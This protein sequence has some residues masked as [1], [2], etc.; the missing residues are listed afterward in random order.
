MLYTKTKLKVTPLILSLFWL[1]LLMMILIPTP[2]QAQ[3][4][5]EFIYTVQ[6]GDV[7]MLIALRYNLKVTD[8]IL[9]NNLT[10]PNLVFPG[11]QLI[12][13]GLPVPATPAPTLTPIP[14]PPPTNTGVTHQVL[15]G[16]TLFEIATFY[17]LSIDALISANDL[18][19][20]DLIQTG[21]ILQIP[22][23]PQPPPE[24]LAAPFVAVTLSEPA[25]MQGRTLVVKVTLA[26]PAAL[27]GQFETLPLFF[28][29]GPEQFWSIVPVYALAEP[30]MYPLTLTT[31]LADGLEMT[32][33]KN[34]TIVEGPYSTENI[35]LDESRET[36]LDPELVR[37]EQ[38]KMDNLWSQVS[39]QPHWA[40][41]FA[42]PIEV[43]TLR[44]TSNFGTRR[45]Y[46]NG[47]V[48]GF[49]GG[50][51]FGG[52]YGTPIYAPAAG[53]VVLAEGLTVRGNAV[54]IDH[55]LG[56]FSGY[57]HLSQLAVMPGQPVLPGE[58]VG[59]LGDTG[60]VTGPHLHWEMRLNGIAVEPL[61]WV[62][63][64]IP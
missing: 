16:E 64:A 62:R 21:Q 56:L 28:H 50:T 32:L 35:Q 47:P 36:L 26:Q 40:G 8:I 5:D 45:S 22:P 48:T 58:V 53:T 17:G 19:D 12:L 31:R 24:A 13:P 6:P 33:I 10:D 46:N 55:G 54:L 25:V 38:E 23:P 41:P 43:S 42:Y 15:P 52:D 11:Q 1:W 51:D 44:I 7:L 39:P 9:A 57:W 34:V 20:P 29:G 18:V 3:G 27:T 59:Y 63:Q 37:L 60:L 2:A 49:H 14:F 30:G 61:Q 4:P